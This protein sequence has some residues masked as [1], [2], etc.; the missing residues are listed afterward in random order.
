MLSAKHARFLV[1]EYSGS[2]QQFYDDLF[3][4]IITVAKRGGSVLQILDF[5]STSNWFDYSVETVLTDL[6]YRVEFHFR[7]EQLNISW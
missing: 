4:N 6:G 1:E 7:N 3:E 2:Y 5:C